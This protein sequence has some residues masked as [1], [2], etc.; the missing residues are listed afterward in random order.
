MIIY[1]S[2]Y[3]KSGTT[4]ITRLLG[5]ALWCPTG[6]SLIAEDNK[7]IAAEGWDRSSNTVIRKGHF[8][9]LDTASMQPVYRAHKLH[10]KA[11]QSEEH[12]VV[13]VVRD[14][15]DIAVSGAHHWNIPLKSCIQNMVFGTNGF[16]SMGPWAEYINGW[17][18]KLNKF[19]GVLCHYEDMLNGHTKLR[20]LLD[21]LGLQVEPQHLKEAYERQSFKNR[22]ADIVERN[23]KGY[24]LG[25]EF[26]LRFMR[27]G[28]AGDWK[29]HFTRQEAFETEAYF[30]ELLRYFGYESTPLWWKEVL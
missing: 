11:L 13:F 8:S 2:G 7:E 9:L 12:R 5:D 25:K 26:N 10:W 24:N 22:V 17:M 15:R 21:K 27:K 30:G 4:W 20:G 16:R 28:I 1:V 29:N 19:D 23:G 6:G 3:P 18:E 14:P